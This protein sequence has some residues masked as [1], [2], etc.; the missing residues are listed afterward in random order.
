MVHGG[1]RLVVGRLSATTRGEGGSTITLICIC[2]LTMCWFY[3]LNLP[4]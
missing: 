2:E 1:A 3:S 4:I